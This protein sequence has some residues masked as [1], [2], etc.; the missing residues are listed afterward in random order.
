M[1]LSHWNPRISLETVGLRFGG[2][3]THKASAAVLSKGGQAAAQIEVVPHAGPIVGAHG[4]CRMNMSV[5]HVSALSVTAPENHHNGWLR[6]D[7]RVSEHHACILERV[8]QD[9]GWCL[10]ASRKRGKDTT[11]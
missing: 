2:T 5:A 7:C 3:R 11:M 8:E 9:G 4:I 1:L 10:P 6:V